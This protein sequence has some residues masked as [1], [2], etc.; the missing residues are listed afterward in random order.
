MKTDDGRS[1][2]RVAADTLPGLRTAHNRSPAKRSASRDSRVAA[3]ALPGLR[4]A[5]NCSPAKRSA[6]RDK[7]IN[8]G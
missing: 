1:V 8:A 6:S 3:G 7:R 2:F 4:T 5:Q